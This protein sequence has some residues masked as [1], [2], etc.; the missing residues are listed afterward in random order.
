MTFQTGGNKRFF[1]E[2]IVISSTAPSAAPTIITSATNVT[3]QVGSALSYTITADNS[4]SSFGVSSNLPAG[5]TLSPSSGVISGTP[6]E[7]VTN[8]VTVSASNSFGGTSTSVTFAIGPLLAPV[9]TSSTNTNAT[10]GQ[11]FSYQITASNSP[12]SFSASNLPAGLS[13]TSNGLISGI[14]TTA[15]SNNVTL[16]ASNAAGVGSKTLALTINAQSASLIA[17]WDFQTT[18]TG[19]TA[20]AA[21]PNAPNIYQAN[22]GSGAIYLNG[23]NGSSTWI[24]ATTGNE[25]TAFGGTTNNAGTGFSTSTSSPAALAL[26]GGTSQS[27]NGK[28]MVLTF[29]M[30]GRKDLAVSYSIQKTTTGFSTNSW[31]YSTNGSNWIAIDVISNIPSSFATVALSN[32]TALDG[33]SNALLRVTFNGSSTASGNN[34]LDNIQLN[35][36]SSS[37]ATPQIS[38]TGTLGSVSTTYGTASTNPTSFQLS[39]TNLAA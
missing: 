36:A 32:I 16:Y 24:T 26:V 38:F 21:S 4:P 5:L 19:G 10:V 6:T 9:I 23:S 27:A 14:P 1:L 34:R 37:T 30:A 13:S 20:A 28:R 35:A 18:T 15:G 8:V 12:T 29:S 31:E 39:G 3:G 17:G 7:S 33:A 25:V 11:V 2:D 22:F